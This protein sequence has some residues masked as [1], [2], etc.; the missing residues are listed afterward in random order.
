MAWRG[1]GMKAETAALS[2]LGRRTCGSC[3]AWAAVT[4]RLRVVA[5]RMRRSA[6]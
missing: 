1:G 5:R 2:H 4:E 3:G 6:F